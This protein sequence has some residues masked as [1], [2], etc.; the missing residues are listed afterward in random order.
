MMYRH[1]SLTQGASRS[2]VD[3]LARDHAMVTAR[4]REYAETR[5][6]C[7]GENGYGEHQPDLVSESGGYE[8]QK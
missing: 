5:L 8:Q 6:D 1:H 4:K 3:R 2:R 7:K